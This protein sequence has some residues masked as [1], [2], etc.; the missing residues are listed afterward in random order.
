MPWFIPYNLLDLDQREFVDDDV[1]QRLFISGF[2]G[3]GKS[4]VLVHKLIKIFADNP[5]AKCCVISFTHSL[6]E[7]FKL[8][9][10]ESGRLSG[11]VSDK[12]NSCC[13]RNGQIDL[14]TKYEFRKNLQNVNPILYDFIMIDEVQD[15]CKSDIENVVNSRTEKIYLGGDDNQSLYSEDPQDKEPTLTAQQRTE[16]IHTFNRTLVRLYRITPSILTTAKRIMPELH[17]SLNEIQFGHNRDAD[18][19]L[20][21]AQDEREEVQYVF[22]NALTYAEDI[23]LTAILLPKHQWIKDFC[24][25][26][27][28]IN[29]VELTPDILQYFQSRNYT[30]LNRVFSE[31]NIRLEYVGNEHGSFRNAKENHNVVLMTY[32]SAKGMDFDNVFI[33]FLSSSRH[34]RFSFFLPKPLMVATTRSNLNLTLS[35]SGESMAFVDAIRNTCVEIDIDSD[36]DNDFLDY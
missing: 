10:E 21:N 22:E 14:V 27:L 16:L 25:H 9:I 35:Y 18:V 5:S 31:N 33:P 26:I 12:I 32:H 15:L 20:A 3:T 4:V 29:N 6:L 30:E 13:A 11:R 2:A 24:Q 1:N 23:E 36:Y 7:M 28:K 34:E 8:G 17:E 19:I